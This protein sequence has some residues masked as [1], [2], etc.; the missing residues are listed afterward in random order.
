[1]SGPA[2][3]GS[4]PLPASAT[5]AYRQMRTPNAVRPSGTGQGQR[6]RFGDDPVEI[7]GQSMDDGDSDDLRKFVRVLRANRRLH[8]GVEI[9]AGLDDHWH[10]FRR[11]DFP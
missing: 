10:L 9:L 4:E 5:V 7:R 3:A 8:R 1:M 6:A 11:F 2:D